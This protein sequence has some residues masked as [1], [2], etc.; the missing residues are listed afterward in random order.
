MPTLPRRG[1]LAMKILLSTTSRREALAAGAAFLLA[2]VPSPPPALAV[3]EE[4][5]ALAPAPVIGSRIDL[6]LRPKVRPLPRR[7]MD[8][9]FSVTLMRTSYQVADALDFV[10]MDKFQKDF[11]NVRQAEWKPYKDALPG[12]S[13]GELTDPAY[14]DFISYAQYT[15]LAQNMR[16]GQLNFVELIDANGTAVPVSRDRR[17]SDNAKLPAE[18]SERVGRI[19]LDALV[20][21]YPRIAPAVPRVPTAASL[22]EGVQKISNIFEINDYMLAATLKPTDGGFE[23][24]LAA[25]ATLWGQQVLALHRDF[26][27]G[28]AGNAFEVKVALAYLRQ[29]SVPATV[30]SSYSANQVTH[31]FAFPPNLVL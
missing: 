29:C 15:T 9:N 19:V 5:A 28:A 26:D 24:T 11:F 13:Q 1:D 3:G 8:L 23:W 6:L 2:V 25:P 17:Y 27:G 22:L 21:K 16:D 31:R 4:L 30:T 20:A 18:H 14:F 7:A 10:P 12:I